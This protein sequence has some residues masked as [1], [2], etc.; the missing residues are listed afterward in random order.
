MRWLVYSDVHGN[1]PAF[2]ATL[3]D[4][5]PYDGA[6][7]LGDLVNYGP[8]SNECVDLA[9][10]LKNPILIMGNHEEA[11]LKGN[12]EGSNPVV[13]EFFRSTYI[14][15]KRKSEI[16]LFVDSYSDGKY[17]FRH[18]YK[19]LYVYPDTKLQL[20]GSYMIGHSHHQF[21]T[22]N[23]GFNLYNAGS[24]G[25]NRTTIDLA[26]YIIYDD[27]S[28]Y[29]ELKSVKFDIEAVICEMQRRNYPQVC[30]DY[31]LSKKRA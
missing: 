16:Q 8:W 14:E 25:Q 26:Q 17:I 24:V 12:Y 10:S 9:L 11:Y 28:D 27:A 29:V 6:I 30:I 23:A 31:Y 4:C 22:K 15:F 7:C 3:A 5:G 2:E 18:T 20:D 1:L 13:Q 19:G 21:L